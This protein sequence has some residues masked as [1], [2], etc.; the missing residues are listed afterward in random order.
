MSED[1]E[2]EIECDHANY[3]T[4]YEDEDVWQGVCTDCGA[5]LEDDKTCE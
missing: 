1:T 2:W 5:E 4:T 3:D